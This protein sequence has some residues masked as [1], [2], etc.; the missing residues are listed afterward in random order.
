MSD[1]KIVYILLIISTLLLS[2]K[3]KKKLTKLESA[4]KLQIYNG[5]V[6]K[7]I[8]YQSLLIKSSV[9]FESSKKKLNLKATVKIL[10]DSLII[11]S[12][13][14]GLGIEVARIKFTNDSIFILD[15]LSSQLTRGDYQYISKNYK[16]DIGYAD[17]QS[18]LTNELFIY[19][20]EYGS[21]QDEFVT[22]FRF[23]TGDNKLDMYRKTKNSVENLVS[24][25]EQTN[26]IK[27]YIIN[28]I[29]QN[30]NLRISFEDNYSEQFN[31]VP[32]KVFITSSVD[33]K[34]NKINLH[35][36][37]VT[38]NKKLNFSFNIPSKYK[39]IDI[40]K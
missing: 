18:I 25:D 28:D 7:Y 5:I 22:G 15:R 2:C 17:I 3:T 16:I 4:E 29:P 35:Y 19:P 23:G 11:I 9:K 26:A 39:I 32:K 38:K 24:V 6:S 21:L 40:K 20:R 37:K 10:K 34:Y 14:P 31:N 33:G 1:F 27:K 12:L 13:S 30:R 36:T 8:D